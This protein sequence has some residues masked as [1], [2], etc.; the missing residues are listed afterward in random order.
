[1]WT[2][3]LCHR[4]PPPTVGFLC[5]YEFA[6]WENGV[7]EAKPHHSVFS[8]PLQRLLCFTTYWVL[9]ASTFFLSWEPVGLEVGF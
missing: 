3:Y 1:M 5:L 8:L 2:F 9:K 4:L 6:L 7:L